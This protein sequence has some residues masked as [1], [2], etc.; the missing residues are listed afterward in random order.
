MA[1]ASVRTSAA[2]IGHVPEPTPTAGQD[3]AKPDIVP[4]WLRKKD[5]AGEQ[6]HELVGRESANKWIGVS[7]HQRPPLVTTAIDLGDAQ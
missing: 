6:G 2:A 4:G 1:P 5:L 3:S 7:V